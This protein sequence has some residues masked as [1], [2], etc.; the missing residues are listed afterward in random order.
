M[1]YAFQI[2][3]LFVASSEQ[4]NGVYEALT[5]SI[6]QNKE[7]WNKEM[8]FLIPSLGQFLIAMICK[9]QDY[10]RQFI[11]QISEIV[12]HLMGTNIRMEQTA[13]QISTAM[14]ERLGITDEQ[15]VH[16]MLF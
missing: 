15:V 13:L 3:A 1:G 12:I 10:M 5:N 11:P 9:F 8:Q 7:N 2:Y 16:K 6:I 14:F 4:N